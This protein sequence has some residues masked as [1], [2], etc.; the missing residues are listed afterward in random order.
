MSFCNPSVA[1]PTSQLI[2]QPFFSS[3]TS[4]ALNLR[5][6]ASRPCLSYFMK[7]QCTVLKL[8][9]GRCTQIWNYWPILYRGSPGQNRYCYLRTIS[10][11]A[12]H[13]P[14]TWIEKTERL[15]TT[16]F[17]Q[18]GATAHTVNTSMN[19]LRQQFPEKLVSRFG[20]IHWS[21]RSPN[22]SVLDFFLS[23]G[24]PQ[25]EGLFHS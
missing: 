16:W 15:E 19:R 4:Q 10:S 13:L 25:G 12:Q 20:D 24:L 22:L 5:H 3:P 14:G 7:L 8:Q 6:L 11:H 18:D 1:S 9:C 2:L 21:S 17:Q 23:L